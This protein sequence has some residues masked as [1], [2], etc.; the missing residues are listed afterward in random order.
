MEFKDFIFQAWKVMDFK[1]S[2][3][4]IHGK[5]KFCFV[6]RGVL[7]QRIRHVF[8]W[9]PEFVSVE[10]LEVKKYPQTR[11]TVKGLKVTTKPKVM[12]NLKRSWKKSWNLN[13]SEEYKPCQ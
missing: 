2:V 5:L 12:K 7:K 6:E 1:L 4:E 11:K 9:T 13:I 8:W 10:L 3:L